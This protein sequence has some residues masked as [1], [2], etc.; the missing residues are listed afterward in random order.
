MKTYNT[1][2]VSLKDGTSAIWSANEGDW[3][4]FAYDGT[5][6]IVKKDGAWVGIYNIDC[7]RCVVVK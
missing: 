2:E 3:D 1:I 7:V 4:D 5:V 6:F